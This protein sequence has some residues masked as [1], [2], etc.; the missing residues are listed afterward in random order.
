MKENKFNWKCK[1]T[2]NEEFGDYSRMVIFEFNGERYQVDSCL[3]SEIKYLLSKGI[4]TTESCCGH[5]KASGY[6]VVR[7][8]DI[9][10]MRLLG[11]KKYI[12]P[13]FPKTEEFFISKTK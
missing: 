9:E 2:G 5:K 3:E 6:I 8:E 12:N 10:S 7:D 11:Y 13:N 4:K 1:C